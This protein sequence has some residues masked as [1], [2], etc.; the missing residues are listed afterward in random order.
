[1][2][3]HDGGRIASGIA[4]SLQHTHGRNVL[5]RVMWC[6]LEN[7]HREKQRNLGS[8]TADASFWM[9]T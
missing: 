8:T 7:A 1:M 5:N 4:T 3:A 2:R 9:V 6:C